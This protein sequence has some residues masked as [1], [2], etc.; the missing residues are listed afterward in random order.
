[1]SN[2]FRIEYKTFS[3]S[4][5]LKIEPDSK[6]SQIYPG[7][8]TAMFE[9]KVFSDYERCVISA[10]A[11]ME[12]VRLKL[13]H[14]SELKLAAEINPR[15][16]NGQPTLSKDWQMSEILR[17]W[18]YDREMEKTGTISA[19]AQAKVF[20]FTDQPQHAAAN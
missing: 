19:T 7:V 20:G 3:Y 18:I 16:N 14:P 4:I 13:G 2:S 15:L 9:S 11:L 17:L 10:R 6:L 8:E 1:M 5:T 12:Q